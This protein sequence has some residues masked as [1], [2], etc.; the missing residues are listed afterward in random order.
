[1]DTARLGDGHVAASDPRQLG[2]R[3]GGKRTWFGRMVDVA[4]VCG[5]VGG[6][7]QGNAGSFWSALGLAIL[8]ASL[9]DPGRDGSA[10]WLLSNP[11]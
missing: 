3:A 4:V 9:P 10:S 11:R 1:M 6:I 2:G 8:L 5:L 7:W